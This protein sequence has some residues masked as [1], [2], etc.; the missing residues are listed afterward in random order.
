MAF[1]SSFKEYNLFF[2]SETELYG[3]MFILHLNNALEKISNFRKPILL[4]EISAQ[5]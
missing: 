1:S 4:R 3:Y 2:L 5:N